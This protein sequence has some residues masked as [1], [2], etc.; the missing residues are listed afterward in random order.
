[1]SYLD[2]APSWTDRPLTDPAL[3]T[4]VIDLMLTHGQR[5]RGTFAAI[6]CDPT[7][8]FRAVITIDLRTEFAN[9]P[10]PQNTPNHRRPQ[11]APNHRRPQDASN[12]R[13]PQDA[14]NLRPPQDALNHH[15][16]QDAPNLSPPLDAPDLCA[17]A[18]HPIVAA[19]RTDPASTL[20]L[21]LGRPGPPTSPAID[22]EWSTAATHLCRA[23]QVPLLGFYIATHTH[24]YQPELAQPIAA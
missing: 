8:R 21:A 5:S 18:L 1:M 23:A 13:R 22:N 11:D 9:H 6:L 24:I 19:L 20:L 14:S 15:T 16:L 7:A 10:P 4:D 2:L 12:H 17:T 3:A